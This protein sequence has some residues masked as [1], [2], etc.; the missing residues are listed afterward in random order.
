MLNLVFQT[1]TSFLGLIEKCVYPFL[2]SI[3]INANTTK[4]KLPQ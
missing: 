2:S 3:F 4:E 1:L